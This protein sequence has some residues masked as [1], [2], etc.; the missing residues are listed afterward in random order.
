MTLD[1]LVATARL[2]AQLG[3]FDGLEHSLPY[4]E[5]CRHL[6]APLGAIVIFTR[7]V[8]HH[9]SGWWKNPDYE[10]CYH[11]SVSFADGFARRKGEVMARAFFGHDVKLLWVE[12][13]HT[14]QGK[15]AEVWHYRL[16]CDEAWMPIKPSGEVYSR[17]MPAG[18]LSFSERHDQ[19]SKGD[20]L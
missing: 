2:S 3:T 9:S 20:R 17:A 6:Y 8:G 1:Q 12:P 19:A 10:R 5:A 15:S 16:F 14:R 4:M 11:L 7:D 13:P 18:W